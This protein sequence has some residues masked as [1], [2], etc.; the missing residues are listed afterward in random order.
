MMATDSLHSGV[1]LGTSFSLPPPCRR[2]C[3]V[4]AVA[5]HGTL[6]SAQPSNVQASCPESAR[7]TAIG[8]FAGAL[9]ARAAAPPG[10]R[11]RE[12]QRKAKAEG[13]I[14]GRGTPA[15][16]K[17]VCTWGGHGTRQAAAACREDALGRS[18]AG[19]A[20]CRLRP[21]ALVLAGVCE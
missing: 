16:E 3:S 2:T 8:A 7:P 9:T 6:P 11:C 1:P 13:K 14:K 12:R 18:S 5:P 15:P 10:R 17:P 19:L 21:G 4:G 20:A